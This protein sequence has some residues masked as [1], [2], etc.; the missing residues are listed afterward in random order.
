MK[1]NIIILFLF[2]SILGFS[3]KVK[4][5][6]ENVLIDGAEVCKFEKERNNTTLLT[7]SGEEFV[8]IIST[9]YPVKN[10]ARSQ[11][12]GHN[13]PE[14]IDNYVYTVRFLESGKELFTDMSPKD[15]VRTLFKSELIT[16]KAQ[17][18]NDKVDK[19]ITKYNNENLKFKIN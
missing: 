10:P 2:F 4:F 16:D 8:N 9:A 11:P 5:K 13:Y 15:I 7:K 17:L 14:T 19:F 6:D 1:K 3:Q 12:G 18:D